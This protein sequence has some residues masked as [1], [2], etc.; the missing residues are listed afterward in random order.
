MK[1]ITF[2]IDDKDILLEEALEMQR[3]YW[4]GKQK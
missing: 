1:L 3:R 4:K 2:R